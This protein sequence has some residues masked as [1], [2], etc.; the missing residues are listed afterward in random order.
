MTVKTF[1]K[2]IGRGIQSAVGE[3]TKSF[4]AGIGSVLGPAAGNALIEAAP[5]LLAFKT[6]GRIPGKKGKKI[7]ILAHSGEYILPCNSS[8]TKK[9]QLVVKKNKNLKNKLKKK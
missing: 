5:A 3:T 1:F 9:Q 7:L 6:G 8:P 4:G 2:K